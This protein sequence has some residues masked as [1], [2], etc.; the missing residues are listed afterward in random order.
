MPRT[1]FQIGDWVAVKEFNIP[2]RCRS[3]SHQLGRVLSY[4]VAAYNRWPGIGEHGDYDSYEDAPKYGVLFY[5][6]ITD[7]VI[8]HIERPS[9]YIPCI[10]QLTFEPARYLRSAPETMLND[11]RFTYA[12]FTESIAH[13]VP[14]ALTIIHSEDETLSFNYLN[15]A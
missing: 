8:A 12:F 2:K 4:G 5:P 7:T 11:P 14:E 10:H 3:Y 15:V 1:K 13:Q 9:Q 6:P